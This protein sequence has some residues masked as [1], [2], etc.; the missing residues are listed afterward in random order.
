L[1][2]DPTAPEE[3]LEKMN[4]LA[5]EESL[6]QKLRQV[7]RLQAK[8][9]TWEKTAEASLMLLRGLQPKL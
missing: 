5:K 1:L 7:G 6:R 9:F 2:F 3:L 8:K 4:R